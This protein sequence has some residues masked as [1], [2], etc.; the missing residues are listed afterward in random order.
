MNKQMV[1]FN[2]VRTASCSKMFDF[3]GVFFTMFIIKIFS[4]LSFGRR[5]MVTWIQRRPRRNFSC[6]IRSRA[7][8]SSRCA[9]WLSRPARRGFASHRKRGYLECNISFKL[10]DFFQELID[11]TCLR[12]VIF[13][14]R[15]NNQIFLL[16]IQAS[17]RIMSLCCSFIQHWF[18]LSNTATFAI[19]S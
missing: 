12:Y 10:F 2:L 6:R 19:L 15:T 13:Y 3:L 16:L 11:V 18:R 7:E 9:P 5:G 8:E 14:N 4:R 17:K 1:Y